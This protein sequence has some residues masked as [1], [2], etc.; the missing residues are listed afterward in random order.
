MIR[1]MENKIENP[2]INPHIYDSLIY[3]KELRILIRE[4][5]VSSINDVGNQ[6]FTCIR[7]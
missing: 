3:G 1:L 6:I 4:R 2:E 7:G 5:T